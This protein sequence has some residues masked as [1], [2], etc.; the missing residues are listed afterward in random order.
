MDILCPTADP[1]TSRRRWIM[2]SGIS[3]RRTVATSLHSCI[4]AVQMFL[5]PGSPV[6][7][8]KVAPVSK[9]IGLKQALP[10]S[11]SQMFQRMLSRIG[12]SKPACI[13]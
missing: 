12:A 2:A 10:H 11:L 13:N 5:N 8:S 4:T 6:I 3:M 9:L 7:R 1:A